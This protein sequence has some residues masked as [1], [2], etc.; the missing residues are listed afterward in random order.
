MTVDTSKFTCAQLLSGNPA[1]VEAAVCLSGYFN[2]QRNNTVFDISILKHNSEAAV[3]ACKNNP[4]KTM[5]QTVKSLL[6]A[7]TK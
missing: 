4:N 1:A 5:M 6:P 2:G 3:A 7:K